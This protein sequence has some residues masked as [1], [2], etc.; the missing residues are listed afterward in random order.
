MLDNKNLN[1]KES[2]E[3]T[4]KGNPE[5]FREIGVDFSFLIALSKKD[6]FEVAALNF[7]KKYGMSYSEFVRML[8]IKREEAAIDMHYF[9][10]RDDLMDWEFIEAA[11]NWWGAK[12]E[13]IST[14]R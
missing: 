5:V 11:K 6:A 10:M 4:K 14:Q 3:S 13:W 8:E 2:K 7:K 12:I 1:G 9:E